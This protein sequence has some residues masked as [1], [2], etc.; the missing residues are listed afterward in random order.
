MC[1][2]LGQRDR[3]VVAEHALHRHRELERLAGD[4]R[5]EVVVAH[6]PPAVVDVL[7]DRRFGH[8]DVRQVP[9]PPQVVGPDV[10][11]VAPWRSSEPL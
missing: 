9:R 3:V 2:G 5:V 6:Q 11:G 1:I 8:V 7:L 10:G 4:V